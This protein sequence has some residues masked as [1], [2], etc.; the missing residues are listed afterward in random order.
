MAGVNE[1]LTLD[2]GNEITL[3]G[4]SQVT[5]DEILADLGG[6]DLQRRLSIMTADELETH[7]ATYSEDERQEF[8]DAQRR[9][10]LYCLGWGVVDDPQPDDLAALNLLGKT[11]EFENVRRAYWL[12]YAANLTRRDKARIVGTVLALTYIGV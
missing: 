2:N 11:S 12:L 8:L 5:M 7:F 4:V 6:F 1:K 3:R 10:V 9:E